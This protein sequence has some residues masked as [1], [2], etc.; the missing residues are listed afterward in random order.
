MGIATIKCFENQCTEEDSLDLGDH[1]V[2]AWIS[3]LE[4][5][6]W[7]ITDEADL[8]LCEA[9]GIYSA[10]QEAFGQCPEHAQ[11]AGD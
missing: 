11:K 7:V 3:N 5:A 1:D 6:G 2:E 4:F 9:R 8:A 10:D